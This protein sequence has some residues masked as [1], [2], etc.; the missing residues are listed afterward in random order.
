MTEKQTLANNGQ[1]D[2]IFMIE[3]MDK[4]I[5][6]LLFA[7][8][9][10]LYARRGCNDIEWPSEWSQEEIDT[11]KQLMVEN[12]SDELRERIEDDR[13]CHDSLFPFDPKQSINFDS[14]LLEHIK[15]KLGL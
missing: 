9:D 3:E 7:Q 10:D 13:E 12:P 8:L 6:M 11:Y 15:K 5:L 2:E 1:F 14:D 4:R